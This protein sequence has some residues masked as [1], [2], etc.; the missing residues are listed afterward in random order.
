[1]NEEQ[2]GGWVLLSWA[3]GPGLRPPGWSWSW[4]G[5]HRGQ[6]AASKRDPH[7]QGLHASQ[8]S[9]GAGT[10]SAQL[11]TGPWPLRAGSQSLQGPGSPSWPSPLITAWFWWHQHHWECADSAPRLSP[12]LSRN[13]GGGAGPPGAWSSGA[14]TA[15]A[16]VVKGT[17]WETV[18]PPQLAQAPSPCLSSSSVRR[19]QGQHQPQGHWGPWRSSHVEMPRTPP[20]HTLV[21]SPPPLTLPAEKWP[22]RTC[23]S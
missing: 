2:A 3:R 4:W 18:P 12:L 22:P 6:G 14:F 17:H 9:G 21:S 11:E 23:E 5:S 1:M 10:G 15:T 8:G 20:L 16:P 7:W 13:A 19:S